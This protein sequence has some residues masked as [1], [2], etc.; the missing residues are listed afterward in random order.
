[1]I[2]VQMLAASSNVSHRGDPAARQGTFDVHVP[3]QGLWAA[4]VGRHS[5]DGVKRRKRRGNGWNHA[6][7]SGFASWRGGRRRTD[8]GTARHVWRGSG[9][10]GENVGK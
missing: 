6:G 1:M 10:I 7:E 8:N 5:S 3:L 2:Q 4:Q 9:V